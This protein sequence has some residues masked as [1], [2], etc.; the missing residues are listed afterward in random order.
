MI[1]KSKSYHPHE[2]Q[3]GWKSQWKFKPMNSIGTQIELWKSQLVMTQVE[4]QTKVGNQVG[5]LRTIVGT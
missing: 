1:Y 3:Q 5:L 2:E 4:V